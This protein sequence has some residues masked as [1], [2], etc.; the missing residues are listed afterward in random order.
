MIGRGGPGQREPGRLGPSERVDHPPTGTQTEVAE[1][2]EQQTGARRP[3][4]T[5][6]GHGL[7]HHVGDRGPAEIERPLRIMSSE[8]RRVLPEED[9]DVVVADILEIPRPARVVVDGPLPRRVVPR[10]AG[11]AA[12]VV[13]GLG[14]RGDG[15]GQALTD[16]P[17]RRPG[18]G[19]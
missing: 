12:A 14:L 5:P 15:E 3:R 18:E 2:D 16:E 13:H 10:L 19:R 17:G 1:T 8:E 6:L 9:A 4:P 11:P 7:R